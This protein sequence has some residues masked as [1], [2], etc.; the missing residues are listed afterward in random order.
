M[1]MLSSNP[2]PVVNTGPGLTRQEFKG[3]C[4][5][6]N[7]VARYKRDGFLAHMARSAPVFMDV[8]EIGDFRTAV[9]QVRAADAWFSQLPAAVRAKFNNSTAEF[10]DGASKMTREELRELGL[11]ELRR[12]DVRRRASDA[13]EAAGGGPPAASGTVT[14]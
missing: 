8:S 2:R 5:V 1:G 3:E 4:D 6:N 7:I 11:A 9:E 10:L 14:S 12:D 13:K